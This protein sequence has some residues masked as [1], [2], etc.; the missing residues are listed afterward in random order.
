[1]D[2]LG[3]A[4]GLNVGRKLRALGGSPTPLMGQWLGGGLFTETGNDAEK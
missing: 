3:S 2:S 1:M 4:V